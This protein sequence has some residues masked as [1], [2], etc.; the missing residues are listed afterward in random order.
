MIS[1]IKALE[2]IKNMEEGMDFRTA[3]GEARPSDF[4]ACLRDNP[5][6]YDLYIEAIKHRAETY[7]S[8]M[9]EI[10]DNEEDI[11]RAKLKIQ[12]RQWSAE[13]D[14]PKRFGSK[15]DINVTNTL[16]LRLA[17]EEAEQRVIEGELV[18]RE[19][20][21]PGST[22]TLSNGQVI[23]IIDRPPPEPEVDVEIEFN[24]VI[25]EDFLK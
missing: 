24:P 11:Q 25:D 5:G 2:F 7:Q 10:A 4:W 13:K 8:D 20:P 21:S 15:V 18:K 6:L 16:N 1:S 17:Q 22:H 9:I 14:N 19:L 23:N 12:V 3:I